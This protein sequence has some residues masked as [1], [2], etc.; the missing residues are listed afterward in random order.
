M[1]SVEAGKVLRVSSTL[2]RSMIL[3]GRLHGFFDGNV[4]TVTDESVAMYADK[5]QATKAKG[6]CAEDKQ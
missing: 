3:D 1:T 5:R 4:W 6:V 2:V